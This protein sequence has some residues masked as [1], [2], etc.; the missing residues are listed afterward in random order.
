VIRFHLRTSNRTSQYKTE[1]V[2]ANNTALERRDSSMQEWERTEMNLETAT[3]SSAAAA[4]RRGAAAPAPAGSIRSLTRAEDAGFEG[5][6]EPAPRSD[7]AARE[8]KRHSSTCRRSFSCCSSRT[9]EEEAP[10]QENWERVWMKRVSKRE[11]L[12]CSHG[13]RRRRRPPSRRCRKRSGVWS[14]YTGIFENLQVCPCAGGA[15]KP[16]P[17]IWA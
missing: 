6:A 17:V 15:W 2:S 8:R 12:T 5:H 11:M 7:S 1:R 9:A 3:L 4:V 10:G 13:R 16:W 14:I